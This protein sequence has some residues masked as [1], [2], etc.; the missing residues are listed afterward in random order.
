MKGFTVFVCLA[1]TLWCG[2]PLLGQRVNTDVVALPTQAT[3]VSDPE[4]EQRIVLSQKNL[5]IAHGA[6]QQV[7][8]TLHYDPAYVRLAYP[9]GDIPPE[10]GV[11][12]DVIIRA[13]RS[14]QI[15]LQQRIHEDMKASFSSYPQNWKL[16]R[17]DANI[18]HRRV[19]NLETWFTRQ[20][21]S[22]PVTNAHHNYR[23]GD[24]VSWRLNNGLA[25]IGIVA[26][27]YTHD[28]RPF[29]IHNIGAGAQSEDVL[30]SWRIVGHY[31]YFPN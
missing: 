21:K 26:D 7:G 31:R 4:I 13:F 18:D 12:A 20:G 29:I 6:E 30:F 24:I 19:P 28:G 16:T 17:P 2:S 27:R 15:D 10:R 9:G 8:K 23:P 22:L 11:C 3:P 25:H 14:Q 5:S 1:V